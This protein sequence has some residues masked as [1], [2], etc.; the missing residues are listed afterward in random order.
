MKFERCISINQCFNLRIKLSYLKQCFRRYYKVSQRHY[1]SEIESAKKECWKT[2][3]NSLCGVHPAARVFRA[4]KES[5]RM[6]P[7]S[8]RK[9][10]GT[11]TEV[12]HWIISLKV[13]HLF[14]VMTMTSSLMDGSGMGG[15]PFLTKQSSVLLSRA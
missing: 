15:L 7:Q 11:Y 6:E 9:P 2:Y 3:Y 1:K 14:W 13:W 5:R 4:L 8:L 10:D 12:T